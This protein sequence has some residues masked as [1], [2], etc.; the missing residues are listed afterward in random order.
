MDHFGRAL[1]LGTI[2]GMLAMPALLAEAQA[3]SHGLPSSTFPLHA[4]VHYH[5][6]VSNA[7][8]DCSWSFA[9][10]DEATGLP[11]TTLPTKHTRTMRQLRRVGGWEEDGVMPLRM[12]FRLWFNRFLSS[13][14]SRAACSDLA[15]AQEGVGFPKHVHTFRGAG[16]ERGWTEYL[17]GGATMNLICTW[18]G[19]VEIESASSWG[20]GAV[21]DGRV[22]RM[23]QRQQ[24][25]AALGMRYG[26]VGFE[27][28]RA[29]A[30]M[31]RH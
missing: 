8:I 12:S 6:E 23:Y 3:P 31:G 26:A 30:C 13:S 27:W 9:V 4:D 2:V 15:Q 25:D 5:A 24:I 21:R 19:D 10:C 18:A 22:A 17:F 11:V 28:R 29:G 14:F 16:G 1:L 7:T 20:T